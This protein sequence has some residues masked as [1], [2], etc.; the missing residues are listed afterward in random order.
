MNKKI[1]FYTA[2]EVAKMLH[3]D[4]TTLRNRLSKGD[5]NLPTSLRCG[6]RRLFPKED[7]HN[8]LQN[9]S[10]WKN[11][12]STDK[13]EL[14]LHETGSS[15]F[16]ILHSLNKKLE[17]LSDIDKQ[18]IDAYMQSSDDVKQKVRAILA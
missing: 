3:I 5:K 7:L 9:Q 8:W 10:S 18:T 11:S 12:A 15:I 1:E 6:R 4:V 2:D 17:Q 16:N 14:K 13:P